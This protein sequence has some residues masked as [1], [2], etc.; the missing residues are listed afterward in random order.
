ML[1]LKVV[2]FI[3]QHG[4]EIMHLTINFLKPSDLADVLIIAS[5]HEGKL[6]PELTRRN[7]ADPDLDEACSVQATV[8]IPDKTSHSFI[9]CAG[10]LLE[11]EASS[12]HR[13]ARPTD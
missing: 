11:S 13:C 3:N 7:S 6:L 4:R 5:A 10:R 1:P 12:G 8:E 9:L 2:P